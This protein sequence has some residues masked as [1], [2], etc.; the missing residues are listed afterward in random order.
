MHDELSTGADG[1]VVS[2]YHT[3]SHGIVSSLGDILHL[4]QRRV[5]VRCGRESRL[6]GTL[7]EVPQEELILTDP[8][9]RFDE[10]GIDSLSLL[11]PFLDVLWVGGGG[12]IV[13]Q[14]DECVYVCVCVGVCG[15]GRKE[16]GDEGE[17][18]RE[19]EVCVCKV[20]REGG[21]RR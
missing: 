6:H 21:M 13:R 1:S 14:R 10:E 4:L 5:E 12:W 2:T 15:G 3:E 18:G 7:L 9:D 17:E 19:R 20:M 16:R 8:L 11:Q